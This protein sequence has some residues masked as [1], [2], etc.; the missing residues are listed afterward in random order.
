MKNYWLDLYRLLFPSLCV[1]CGRPLVATEQEVC[2]GCLHAFART[3]F[4]RQ[5]DNQVE[6]LFW[7][8]VPI[9]KAM[10][11]CYFVKGG[12]MQCLLHAL[13]YKNKPQLGVQ[14]GRQMAMECAGWFENVDV[15]VPIPLHANRLRHRGYNQAMCVA[16]GIGLVT[17][18]AVDE[19]LLLRHA[20]TTT[21]TN[22]RVYER[23]QN[24][25]GIFSV[26]SAKELY[27]RKHIVLI[28]DV[29]TTGATLASAVHTLQ[30]VVT[31][32]KISIATVAVASTT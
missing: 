12:T 24:T 22:K 17:G 31:D 32:I 2:L 9:E 1:G 28:D 16:K 3:H 21:Q 18:I 23:W 30:S 6:Q 25:L 7:G 19:G 15:L 8:K 11:W 5:A 26:S 14:L 20:P 4:Y 13:K 10:A 29:I 27:Q